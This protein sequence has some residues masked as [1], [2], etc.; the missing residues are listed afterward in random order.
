MKSRLRPW[1]WRR[2]GLAKRIACEQE[3]RDDDENAKTPRIACVEGEGHK[4][5]SRN[6]NDI[7]G[8]REVSRGHVDPGGTPSGGTAIRSTVADWIWKHDYDNQSYVND[9]LLGHLP[10]SDEPFVD[11]FGW[12][13]IE[14]IPLG[15]R[16]QAIA[17]AVAAGVVSP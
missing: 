6:A 14:D 16:E 13:D 8:V 5:A 3:V 17:K 4:R 12:Y 11:H 2:R 15:L 9:P 10:T 1:R 7:D